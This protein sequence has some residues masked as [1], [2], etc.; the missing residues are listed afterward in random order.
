[1]GTPFTQSCSVPVWM[2]VFPKVPPMPTHMAENV[3]FWETVT[4]GTVQ[5][6][7]TPVISG[8]GLLKSVAAVYPPQFRSVDVAGV[9]VVDG[10]G[11]GCEVDVGVEVGGVV[12]D[13]E[14]DG[15]GLS[16]VDV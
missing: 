2:M 4:W 11:D 13:A 9:E 3:L 10:V 14:G 8:W 16:N 15:V 7:L 6:P 1:M 12:G 5:E